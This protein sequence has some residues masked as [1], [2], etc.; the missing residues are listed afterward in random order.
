MSYNFF[1]QITNLLEHYKNIIGKGNNPED[2]L[3]YYQFFAV[4]K[5]T[6]CAVNAVVRLKLSFDN[7][8]QNKGECALF[9]KNLDHAMNIITEIFSSIS[10]P[11]EREF[12]EELYVIWNECNKIAQNVR[13]LLLGL[14]SESTGNTLD[15]KIT[16]VINSLKEGSF[17]SSHAVFLKYLS[18]PSTMESVLSESNDEHKNFMVLELF[19]L[20]S[21]KKVTK[22]VKHLSKLLNYHFV[23]TIKWGQKSE[24]FEYEETE[25]IFEDFTYEVAKRVLVMVNS[26]HK[27]ILDAV[28]QDNNVRKAIL[29]AEV[30][31]NMKYFDFIVSTLSKCCTTIFNEAS[32]VTTELSEAGKKEVTNKNQYLEENKE[33]NSK[34]METYYKHQN[35][36]S[37]IMVDNNKFLDVLNIYVACFGSE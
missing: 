33:K 28:N 12:N 6:S 5:L 11:D 31:E 2:S 35:Q 1:V 8:I 19:D 25:E 9:F 14:S 22:I 10:K 16:E 27:A 4:F 21:D 26:R 18:L 30:E 24:E 34:V 37:D 3:I 32:Q 7:I 15:V 36:I 23:E 17:T 13:F 29:L 20:L